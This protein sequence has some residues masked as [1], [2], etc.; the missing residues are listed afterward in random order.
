[1]PAIVELVS[2]LQRANSDNNPFTW[3]KILSVQEK[4][5]KLPLQEAFLSFW[6]SQKEQSLD[7][8]ELQQLVGLS[9]YNEIPEIQNYVKSYHRY[10]RV[11][12]D[13]TGIIEYSLN[14]EMT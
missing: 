8:I 11:L 2:L 14:L 6:Q 9:S 7:I 13:T 5:V 3:E 12:Y 10:Q 4:L 1:M